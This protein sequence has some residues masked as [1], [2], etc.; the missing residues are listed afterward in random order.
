MER[1]QRDS[2]REHA[3]LRRA[4]DAIVIDTSMMSIDQVVAR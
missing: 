4:D 1:D 3:P 2:A